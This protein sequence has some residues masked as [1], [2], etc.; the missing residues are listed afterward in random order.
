MNHLIIKLKGEVQSSN[1]DEWKNDL[2]AQ[3]QS[4]NTALLTDNDFVVAIGYVKLLKSA[5]KSLKEAKQ[6]AINQAYDIQ[7]LFAAIDEIS[8]KARQARL[9]LERQINVRKLEIKQGYIQSGLEDVRTFIAQQSTDF[10]LI[11]HSN[12]VDQSRFELA[13]KG[14]ASIKGMESAIADLCSKIKLEISEIAD[15]VTNNGAIIDSL[16]SKHKFLFQDRNSLMVLNE[17][18]LRLTIDKRISLFNEENAKIK[19][20]NAIQELTKLEDDELNFDVSLTTEKAGIM[21]KQKYRLIIDILSSKDAAIE[22]A[23][24][25]RQAYS[26]NVSISNIRLSRPQCD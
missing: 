8:E 26:N 2:L 20:E 3:I 16:P 18:E 4:V 13:V 17:R 19:A 11:D 5:E 7:K 12:F 1:F 24:S 22:I 23:R 14:K 15:K 6:S 9:V 21:E 25:I 10:Q